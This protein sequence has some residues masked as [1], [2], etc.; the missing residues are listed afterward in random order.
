MRCPRCSVELS[1]GIFQNII[2]FRCPV[3]G[4]QAVTMSGLRSMGVDEENIASLWRNAISGRSGSEVG[5]PECKAPMRSLK[6]D[7][8][9]TVFD[10]DLCTRC[11]TLW[12][13]L[14]EL[15]KIPCTPPGHLREERPRDRSEE[16]LAI[17]KIQR[18]NGEDDTPTIF[19]KLGID[20]EWCAVALRILVRIIFKI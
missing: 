5:C 15:E 16:L 1:K 8:G 7:N 20:E 4:G 6:V 12:F 13:D 2:S 18:M 14:G 11:H 19:S 10:I 17:R 3:C 9:E